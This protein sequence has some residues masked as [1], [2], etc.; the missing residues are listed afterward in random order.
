MP[1]NP[2]SYFALP[3]KQRHWAILLIGLSLILV[4]IVVV[5]PVIAGILLSFQEVRLNRPNLTGFVGLT[6]HVDLFADPTFQRAL[7]NTA[8]WVTLGTVMQFCLGLVT[9]LA[10]NRPVRGMKLARTL[11][12][13]PEFLPSSRR[14]ALMSR[15]RT[16]TDSSTRPSSSPK[17]SKKR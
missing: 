8:M 9:A 12:L 1:L 7:R 16:L 4:L 17:R 14:P 11:V 15:P 10:L 5:Y 2:L 13:L 3:S 6:H